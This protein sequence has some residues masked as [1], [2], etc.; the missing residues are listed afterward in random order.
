MYHTYFEFRAF[1]STKLPTLPF[2]IPQFHWRSW[3][4]FY[5]AGSKLESPLLLGSVYIYTYIFFNL[6]REIEVL[7]VCPRSI[8]QK[9][10]NCLFFAV[11]LCVF[12]WFC[13]ASV[14]TT[15]QTVWNR[16]FFFFKLPPGLDA[17]PFVLQTSSHEFNWIALLA[18]P[19]ADKPWRSKKRMCLEIYGRIVFFVMIIQWRCF[20]HSYYVTSYCTVCRNWCEL[21]IWFLLVP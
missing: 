17:W 9:G 4:V 12:C 6:E 1:F 19:Q 10:S 15:V 3:C 21:Y 7:S 20:V 5:F 14:A 18:K 8:A 2:F 13:Q 11:F 16:D